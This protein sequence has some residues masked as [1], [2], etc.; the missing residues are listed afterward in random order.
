MKEDGDEEEQD[1]AGLVVWSGKHGNKVNWTAT[2]NKGSENMV[3]ADTSS[4]LAV[5]SAKLA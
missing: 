4:K 3:V 1:N 5:Y 2:L